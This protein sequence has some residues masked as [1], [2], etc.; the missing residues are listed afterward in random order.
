MDTFALHFPPSLSLAVQDG[1][2]GGSI[3][4]S[5]TDGGATGNG[6]TGAPGGAGGTAAPPR[7]G[8]DPFML[9]IIGMVLALIVFTLFGN[10]KER[11][12]REQMLGSLKKHDRVQTVGGVIGSVVD[13]KSNV[14]VLKVDE[15]SNTRMTFAR[16]AIQQVLSES[17][18]KKTEQE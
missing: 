2:L 12:K 5:G 9:L 4:L 7:T 8:F 16:S 6:A 3:P 1:D 10:R 14:V 11:K 13:V 15:S 18:T 17:D